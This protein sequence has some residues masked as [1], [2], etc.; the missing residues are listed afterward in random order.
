[1]I[2]L[3][4]SHCL[5]KAQCFFTSS[6]VLKA[7]ISIIGVLTFEHTPGVDRPPPVLS[8]AT[9]GHLPATQGQR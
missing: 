9:L 8:C 1:M 6:F 7:F 3:R 2:L 4:A 5:P